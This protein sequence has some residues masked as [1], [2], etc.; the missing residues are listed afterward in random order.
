MPRVDTRRSRVLLAV[1]VL[2]H[3]VAISNQVDGGGGASLL[4][5]WTLSL[6]SPAQSALAGL[7]R[8]VGSV[9][10][11]YV[12]LRGVHRENQ[13]LA[14]RLREL[15]QELQQRREQAEEATRLRALLDLKQIMPVQSIVAHVIARDGTPWYR[16]VTIDKGSA[17]GVALNASVLSPTGVVGRVIRLGAHAA[18][19]Q[20]LIDQQSG[21]GA[22]IERS[23]ITGVVS[24]ISQRGKEGEGAGAE[25]HRDKVPPCGDLAM[26]Y[27][28][29][30][31]DVVP[32]DVVVTS[33]LDRIYPP[34][35]LIGRVCLVRTG[36]GLF[37][38]IVVA[39]SARFDSL[40]EVM[41]VMSPLPDDS[42]P[43]SLR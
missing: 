32:Q 18:R 26:K 42:T 12:G 5:R 31:S 19:V 15:E 3:L 35:L 29:M 13:R 1:L 9:W 28:A 4:Q 11:S 30:L 25:A 24:G 6:L 34:G 38:E 17:D 40:E 22:R 23:R 27:V 20:L 8:G 37:K 7:V 43:Q 36:P 21:A 33:G 39:S 16:T 41:V 2:A 14:G 10:T